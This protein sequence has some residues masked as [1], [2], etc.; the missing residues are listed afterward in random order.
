LAIFSGL[1]ALASAAPAALADPE[2]DDAG[3]NQ[4]SNLA[5]HKTTTPLTI[6]SG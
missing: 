4:A 1:A 6:V 2:I 3:L 5:Q